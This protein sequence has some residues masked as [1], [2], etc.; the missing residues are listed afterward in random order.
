MQGL[1]S[2]QTSRDPRLLVRNGCLEVVRRYYYARNGVRD[3]TITLDRQH[4]W[5]LLWLSVNSSHR[6]PS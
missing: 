6:V 3:E 5:L 1:H 4:S 2:H